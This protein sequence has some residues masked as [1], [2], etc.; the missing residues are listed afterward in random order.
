MRQADIFTVREILCFHEWTVD[1]YAD[2]WDRVMAGTILCCIYSRSRWSDL[3]RTEFWFED[4]ASEGILRYLEF[5]IGR[6]K[7]SKSACFKNIF[8]H[9]VVPVMGVRDDKWALEWLACRERLGIKFCKEQ[10]FMPAPAYNGQP[11]KRPITSSEMK[12]WAKTLLIHHELDISGKRLRS[13]SC[14]RTTLAWCS[15]FGV[16]WQDRLILGG[17]SMG[18]RSVITYSRDLVARPLLQLEQV[19]EAVRDES[20]KPDETRSGRFV[21]HSPGPLTSSNLE[22]LHGASRAAGP[23]EYC[24]TTPDKGVNENSSIV[25]IL[26]DDEER[27]LV[28]SEADPSGSELALDEDA[29]GVSDVIITSSSSDSEAGREC[30]SKR[31]VKL[32]SAPDGYRLVQSIKLKTVHL[33]EL[34]NQYILVCGRNRNAGYADTALMVRWDTPC[35]HT[36]WKRFPR[37]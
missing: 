13:H 2:D 30:P 11:S 34:E 26:D 37:G 4:W 7:C 9:A 20:F 23:S 35:C 18:M 24:P 1:S 8:L 16:S 5:R 33:Q 32:P 36:C 12:V 29:G 31:L 3:M 28:K 15:M 10:P 25:E 14:K 27:A 22:S 19:L 21:K 6:H 17:H